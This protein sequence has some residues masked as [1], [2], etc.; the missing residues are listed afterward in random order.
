LAE[1]QAWSKV[2]DGLKSKDVVMRSPQTKGKV[3]YKKGDSKVWGWSAAT[4]RIR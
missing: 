2:F 3:A 1:G 4:V